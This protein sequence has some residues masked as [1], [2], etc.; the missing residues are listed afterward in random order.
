MVAA[1]KKV[2]DY[3]SSNLGD[4]I[5][6][7]FDNA[8]VDSYNVAITPILGLRDTTIGTIN[9]DTPVVNYRVNFDD[10]FG[11][12]LSLD[13]S[14]Y[15]PETVLLRVTLQPVSQWG[16]TS[17]SGAISQNVGLLTPIALSNLVLK[18]SQERNQSVVSQLQQTVMTEGMQQ[19]IPFVYSFKQAVTNSS[20]HVVSQR[21][22][23]MHGRTLEG[24]HLAVFP[25]DQTGINA[26]LCGDRANAGDWIQ[27]HVTLNDNRLTEYDYSPQ[28]NK[29]ALK[30]Y[31]TGRV[32]GIA[33]NFDQLNPLVV[34]FCGEDESHHSCA[35]LQ[36]LGG[37]PLDTEQKIGYQINFANAESRN[38]VLLMFT[39]K[40]L[41]I[42]AG[43][44]LVQ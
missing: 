42:S 13:R 9:A 43:G 15:F 7:C 1:E 38:H 29:D 4:M 23:A 28:E 36:L 16:F 24:C 22:S 30:T 33:D 34:P 20:Q 10:L 21:V 2:S 37:L 41:T 44:A 11:T 25:Q 5:R 18:V 27:Y 40:N 8:D 26:I 12:F 19:I 3:I 35:S 17:D 39:S 14:Y 6:P 31:F 32:A